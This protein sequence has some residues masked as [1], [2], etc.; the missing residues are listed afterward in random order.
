MCLDVFLDKIL[1]LKV[2]TYARYAQSRV[3]ST[4]LA[5]N[6]VN[7]P[8]P[9]VLARAVQP[10][11]VPSKSKAFKIVNCF[12]DSVFRQDVILMYLINGRFYPHL[13]FFCLSF[14]NKWVI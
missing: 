13:K 10:G 3:G 4:K 5:E 7:K 8:F 12:S 1:L 2:V 11:V 14:Q 9:R 6:P